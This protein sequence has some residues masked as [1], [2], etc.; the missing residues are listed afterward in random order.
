MRLGFSDRFILRFLQP[1]FGGVFLDNDLA[2]SSGLFR[3][4]LKKFATGRAFVPSG[5][6]AALP[7]LLAAEAGS[8][9]FGARVVAVDGNEVAIESGE[10]LAFDH[11]LIATD[12]SAAMQALGEA[13][14][15]SWRAVWTVSFASETSLYPG[16]LLV[17]PCGDGRL[18]RHFV[19]ITNIAP[20][21][22]PSGMHLVVATI[23]DPL[24]L[25][26]DALAAAALREI[27]EIFPRA[28]AALT[29]IDV[30]EIPHALPAQPPGFAG[31][32][33]AP[34]APHVFAGDH[35]TTAS[36]EGAV[37]SGLAAAEKI[38]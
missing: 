16:K 2:T 34:R 1:F 3:Y 24:G 26:A 29:T 7:R 22:A 4:Y 35:L 21:Y 8:I 23:L 20:S 38:P 12:R 14:D 17:L 6:M 18:V 9:R 13:D 25:E 15:S 33:A 37:T 32:R 10:R 19:Q 36:L 11:L 27:S 30:R 28:A 5:G 31:R